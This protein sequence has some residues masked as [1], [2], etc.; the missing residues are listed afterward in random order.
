MVSTGN[1]F[2]CGVL[3]WQPV[4]FVPHRSHPAAPPAPPSL[5]AVTSSHGS[6]TSSRA[7][8]GDDASSSSPSKLH[9]T[10]PFNTSLDI[11]S[12][13]QTPEREIHRTNIC[14]YTSCDKNYFHP[15]A[16]VRRHLLRSQE[17]C[18]SF[19]VPWH[20]CQVSFC[21]LFSQVFASCGHSLSCLR[22]AHPPGLCAAIHFGGWLLSGLPISSWKAPCSWTCHWLTLRHQAVDAAKLTSQI[23][24]RVT[25]RHRKWQDLSLGVPTAE[26]QEPH[27]SVQWLVWFLEHC[28]RHCIFLTHERPQISVC[29]AYLGPVKELQKKEEKQ[30]L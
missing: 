14:G 26:L 21:K 20:K 9:S 6:D 28:S 1:G 18:S 4:A 16:D 2:A 15:A 29:V 11:N 8:V 19:P 7:G 22:K 13:I 30:D 25:N 23:S 3:R 12:P 5:E 24:P 27:H 17:G 10:N